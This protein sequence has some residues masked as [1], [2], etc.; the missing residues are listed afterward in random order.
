MLLSRDYDFIEVFVGHIGGDE[1]KVQ[2]GNMRAFHSLRLWGRDRSLTS[3]PVATIWEAE[4][5][6]KKEGR[7]SR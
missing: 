6:R 3:S 1:R 2:D 4:E 5:M 7:K